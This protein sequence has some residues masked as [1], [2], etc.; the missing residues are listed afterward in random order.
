MSKFIY[1]YINAE[2]YYEC[3]HTMNTLAG[4]KFRNWKLS[5]FK[6]VERLILLMPLPSYI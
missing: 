3:I 2:K 4:I 5:T 6:N 1:V